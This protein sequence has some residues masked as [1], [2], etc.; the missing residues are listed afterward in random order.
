MPK[1]EVIPPPKKPKNL[2][3]KNDPI[4]PTHI[5]ITVDPNGPLHAPITLPSGEVVTYHYEEAD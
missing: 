5:D 1:P 3:I 2:V 4:M